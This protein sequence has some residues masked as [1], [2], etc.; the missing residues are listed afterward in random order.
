MRIDITLRVTESS[1]RGSSER[2]G[3][4][5]RASARGGLAS[6]SNSTIFDISTGQGY[7]VGAVGA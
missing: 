2:W 4:R 3:W 5:L 1:A 6:S 7:D